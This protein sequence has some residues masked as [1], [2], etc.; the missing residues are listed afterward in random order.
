MKKE[1]K[2]QS[3]VN[4]RERHDTAAWRG[5]IESLKPLSRVDIPCEACVNEAREW[6]DQNQ[7]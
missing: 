4:A 6:V 5:H 7:K 3:Q 2:P 1:H